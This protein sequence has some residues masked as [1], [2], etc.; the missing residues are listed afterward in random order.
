MSGISKSQVSR[1]CEEIGEKIKAFLT[2]QLES[3]WPCLWLD[4]TYLKVGR[5]G[6]I[7][8]AA[9][10][11]EGRRLGG[12]DLLVGPSSGSWL[13]AACMVSSWPASRQ[14]SPRSSPS[15]SSAAASIH[16]ANPLKRLNGEINRRAEVVAIFPNEAAITRCVG[17][18]LLERELDVWQHI[19]RPDCASSAIRP[20]GQ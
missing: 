15:P 4:A 17:A 7:V 12:R 5:D 1:L 6:R 3:D 9:A 19:D 8:W 18:I 13:A 20:S 14:P 16:A 2:H 11:L 10:S